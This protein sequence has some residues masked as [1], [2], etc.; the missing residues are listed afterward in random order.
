VLK[1]YWLVVAASVAIGADL[2]AWIL[3]MS[4]DVEAGTPNNYTTIGPYTPCTAANSDPCTGYCVQDDVAGSIGVTCQ[5]T[6]YKNY[7]KTKIYGQLVQT[8]ANTV[9]SN[10]NCFDSASCQTGVWTNGTKCQ[11]S[12]GQTAPGTCGGFDPTQMCASCSTGNFT[13]QQ[14]ATWKTGGGEG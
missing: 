10:V 6:A 11:P 8:G 9:S 3:V 7:T 13:T 2:A 1:L 5:F 4:P 12:G 14:V